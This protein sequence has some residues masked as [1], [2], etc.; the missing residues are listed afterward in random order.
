MLLLTL[1]KPPQDAQF[2]ISAFIFIGKL[3]I[4]GA[5]NIVFLAN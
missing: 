3:G 5:F 2:E 4:S 1:L